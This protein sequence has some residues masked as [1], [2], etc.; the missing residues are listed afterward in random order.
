MKCWRSHPKGIVGKPHNNGQQYSPENSV[1]L[2]QLPSDHISPTQVSL[3][4]VVSDISQN[5]Q[6]FTFLM[7]LYRQSSYDTHPHTRS[8]MNT[9][10][11]ID[12]DT[13]MPCVLRRTLMFRSGIP[14]K[15]SALFRASESVERSSHWTY[16]YLLELVRK[17]IPTPIF[18][19][20][21]PWSWSVSKSTS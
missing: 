18:P 2:N 17:I 10:T 3:I 14:R 6:C 12:S 16:R 11:Q 21:L 20:K 4:F 5:G 7:K 9:Y 13:H 19:K 15:F 1:F 8:H